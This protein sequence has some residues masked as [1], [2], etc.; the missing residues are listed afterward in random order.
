[1]EKSQMV[2]GLLTGLLIVHGHAFAAENGICT[3]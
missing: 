2:K 3:W 1:M